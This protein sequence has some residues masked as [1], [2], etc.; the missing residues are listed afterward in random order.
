M[1]QQTTQQTNGSAPKW[2]KTWQRQYTSQ[3][4][5]AFIFHFNTNDVTTSG[6]SVQDYITKV[7]I[8]SQTEQGSLMDIVVTY[9]RANGLRFPL[10]SM[11]QKFMDMIGL[12]QQEAQG[13]QDDV[14]AALLGSNGGQQ[15]DEELPRRPGQVLPLLNTLLHDSTIRCTVIINHPET[16]A[17][18]AD[19]YMLSPEDR[20]S[21][22][23]LAGWG[24]DPDLAAHG[25]CVILVTDSLGNL[26]PALV[27][28]SNRYES[29]S[30]DLPNLRERSQYINRL[31]ATDAFRGFE[32]KIN[33]TRLA[34]GTAGLGLVHIR[35]ILL[36]ARQTGALTWEL[37]KER[38]DSIIASEFADVLEMI[39]PTY[40]WERIGGLEHVKAFFN[41]SVIQ[42][43]QDGR[44][45][46][47]PMG[48][49]MTGPAGTGKSAVAVAV[50]K[51]AGINAVSLNMSR[52]LGQYVGNSER[53]LE[54][55]IQAI[56]SLSPTIVFID[57]IDQ[58]VSRSEGGD[59][60]VGSRIFKRLLEF[61]SDTTHRGKVVFLAA[62][63][64]PDL[65]DAALRRPGRFDKKIPFLVP[66]EDERASIIRVMA[67]AYGLDIENLDMSP[68]AEACDGWTGAEIEAAAV[69]AIE[70]VEDEALSPQDALVQAFKRLSPST[71]DIQFMTLLAIKETNDTDLLPAKY[72]K[73]LANRTALDAQIE[74]T[75]DAGERSLNLL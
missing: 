72:R 19:A 34:N 65:M 36:R 45:S 64:R 16:L 55:A 44:Y 39:E 50:A 37:V 62:T 57:E 47:V 25:Q 56:E 40:G 38:K 22:I 69:K 1:T 43:I 12:G 61:M 46:R 14:L 5:H 2:A 54:K 67:S 52:I 32:W 20:E 23:T 42:P 53:N 49:L 18:N 30:V 9:D 21:L 35:D 70:L 75:R 4:A 13:G 6:V 31:S 66:D 17:P 60:G 27:A 63:N 33:A 3:V 10:D 74:Q 59:S 26:H 7:L 8:G 71:A 68:L 41:R 73:L 24:S 51:E 28:A 58:T 15:T 29:I 11:R 48:V